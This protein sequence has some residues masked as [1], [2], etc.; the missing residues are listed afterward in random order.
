MAYTT[1][2]LVKAYA[3][4]TGVTDDTL[5]GYLITYAQKEIETYCQRI[6]EAAS[7]TTRLFTVG[8]SNDGLTLYLDE[9]LAAIN[10]IVTN[11]DDG[12][13]GTLLTAAEYITHPRN[14]APYYAIEILRSSD[15]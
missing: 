2:A 13:G 14:I 5:L 4:I 15:N 9:D 10:A 8:K 7:N 1:T 6:F 3:G 11:A 12:S